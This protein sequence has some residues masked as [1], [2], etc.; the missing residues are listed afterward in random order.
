DIIKSEYKN[1]PGADMILFNVRV[2]DN[3]GVREIV[4]KNGKIHY[5]NS[6][7]YGTTQF[8]FK[9]DKIMKHNI[10]FSLYFG[11]GGRFSNGEDSIF[12]WDCLKA[13]LKI[14]S[15][16]KIIA[17]IYNYDSSWFTGYNKKF[18]IDRGALFEA[19]SPK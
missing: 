19:L 5:L 1:Y 2:H 12:L 15:S 11:G 13:D 7:K 10:F 6:L 17:D 3:E 9:R 18:F 14:Y 8:T 16:T 4:K